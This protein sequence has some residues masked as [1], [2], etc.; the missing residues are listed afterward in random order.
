MAGGERVLDCC[1]V[2]LVLWVRGVFFFLFLFWV[3]FVSFKFRLYSS[4]WL[5][6]R[7]RVQVSQ[8]L[9]PLLDIVI[10]AFTALHA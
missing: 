10:A 9:V 7:Y 8:C 4:S 3:F 6:E 5:L 1:L 2:V